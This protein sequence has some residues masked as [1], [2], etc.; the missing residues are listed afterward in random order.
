MAFD[1]HSNFG[2]SV[3][4]VAPVPANT[5]TSIQVSAGEGARFPAAPFNCTIWPP[6]VNP[7]SP[8]AEIVRVTSVVGDVFTIVRA[9]EGTTAINIAAGYNIA[10]TTSVLVFTDI[11]DA[12]HIFA[13]TQ[14]FKGP[15]TFAN[16]N[17]ISFGMDNGTVT[18]SV[19]TAA[20]GNLTISASNSSLS[21]GLVSFANS[22]RITFGL[23]NGT[24]TAFYDQT[25]QP[26]LS[27]AAAGTQNATQNI[28][29]VNSNG[30]TWGMSNNM[31][32]TASH[33]GLTSQSNQAASASNGSFAFQTLIFQDAFNVTWG[34]SAGGIIFA[35][36]GTAAAGNSINVSVSNT[37]SNVSQLVFANANGITWG[38]NNNTLT[39]SHNGITSQ[40][41]QV[42]TLFAA[43]NTTQATSGTANASSLVFAGA[44]GVSVGISNGS[45]VIS[46]N[47]AAGGGITM[48]NWEPVPMLAGAT[49]NV[50]ASAFTRTGMFDLIPSP[51]PVSFNSIQFIASLSNSFGPATTNSQTGNVTHQIQFALYSRSVTDSGATNFSNSSIIV[52]YASVN[53]TLQVL[54]TASS[55]SKT[56]EYRWQTDSTGGSTSTTFS[57]NSSILIAPGFNG[58]ILM[59]I[60]FGGLVKAGEN[61]VGRNYSSSGTGANAQ[62]MFQMSFVEMSWNGNSTNRSTLNDAGNG[63]VNGNNLFKPGHGFYSISSS[64]LPTSVNII[65][66]VSN[67]TVGQGYRYLLF[68][69]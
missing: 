14:N 15:F 47:T 36:V 31:D 12:V 1:A 13:G 3:I 22:N 19:G 51:V 34:T 60:P 62:L 58:R 5:G 25:L 55:S 45:V 33:D 11:E 67:E 54:S 44:G 24:I 57:T 28:S 35:S 23:N 29:F 42:L 52:S 27:E 40:S 18:A 32:I 65:N 8:N 59:G 26:A 39:A 46:G 10:N 30:I 17:G 16:S 53:W 38:L 6:N 56:V 66:D 64:S 43:S 61:W 69:A 9:Q 2:E 50:A 37:S 41:N 21:S 63:N 4:I 20:V 48:S 68:K 7:K 49:F